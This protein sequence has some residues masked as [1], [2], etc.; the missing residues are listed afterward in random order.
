MKTLARLALVG[1]LLGCMAYAADVEGILVDRACGAKMAS[2]NDQKAAMGH[3][4]ECAL[5]PNCTKSGYGVLTADGHYVILDAA[6]N[7]K[8]EAALKASKKTDDMKVTVSGTQT[9]DNIAV[10]S[11]KIM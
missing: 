8:A 3:T 6:G 10:K 11:I 9:G 5:M 1:G 2:S 7:T 4:R